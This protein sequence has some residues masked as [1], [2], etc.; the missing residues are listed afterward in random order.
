MGIARGHEWQAMMS[1]EFAQCRKVGVIIGSPMQF[2]GDPGTAGEMLPHP[3]RGLMQAG[4][5]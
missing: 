1:A 2:D 3:R 4:L 5:R